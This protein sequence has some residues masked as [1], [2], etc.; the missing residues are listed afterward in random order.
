MFVLQSYAKKCGKHLLRVVS[1]LAMF[2]FI[3]I[4]II[5]LYLYL[6]LYVKVVR[7]AVV[8]HPDFDYYPQPLIL[9]NVLS[10]NRI[11]HSSRNI[12]SFTVNPPLEA[13][14][15]LKTWFDS[16]REVE[17][18]NLLTDYSIAFAKDLVDRKLV[19]VHAVQNI[20]S[21]KEC[22]DYWTRSY[23]RISLD[24]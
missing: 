18:P 14:A 10:I 22:G 20:I 3:R 6:N 12:S 8:M 4:P 7:C 19:P 1:C 15:H 2:D 9:V 21:T 11:A 16:V 24:D 17:L 5:V 13:A 23:M